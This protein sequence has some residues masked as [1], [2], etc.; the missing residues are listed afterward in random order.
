MSNAVDEDVP[1]SSKHLFGTDNDYAQIFQMII[2]FGISQVVHIAATYSLA[3][4]LSEA[5]GSAEE[6]VKKNPSMSTQH[7]TSFEP[8]PH[9][10]LS[11]KYG[12]A[13]HLLTP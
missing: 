6:I 5:A 3:E 2:G 11:H 1:E 12:F 9:L 10:A 13:A 4:H 7:S 8:V